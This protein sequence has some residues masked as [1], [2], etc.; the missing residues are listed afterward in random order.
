MD[1]K[2]GLP[3]PGSD[4]ELPPAANDDLAAARHR[5]LLCAPDHFAVDYVINPW[6]AGHVHH[7]DRQRA[8][9]QWRALHARLAEHADIALLPPAPG[10][11]DL[12]FTANA[13][14]VRGN[15]FVPSRFRHAERSG[16]EP[17][18]I[19]WFRRAGM[20]IRPLP[21][22]LYFEGAGDALFDRG[23]P[24]LLWLGHGHRSDAAVAPELQ[25]M[26]GVEVVPLRL[27]DARFYHL[28]T[29]F[30]PLRDGRLLYYP[31]AFDEA[32][33]A[34]IAA[35]IPP[36][37]RIAVTEQDALAFA[38]NAVDLDRVL[39]LNRASAALRG[40][41][42]AWGYTTLETPLD[43]FLKSGG[44]AKCLTLRLDE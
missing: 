29:C 5:L 6:M 21:E 15:D 42:A 22:P 20:R 19:D 43:E 27:V 23:R 4:H 14:L 35:R 12:V 34:Q 28:D 11:P 30:C 44:A 13:G 38:C 17:L 31:A 1:L 18:C 24:G 32:A 41:L 40:A 33:Q 25:R 8:A 3:A 36:Q 10:L 26:L 9:L 7:A 37:Q 39:L 2:H 16:E